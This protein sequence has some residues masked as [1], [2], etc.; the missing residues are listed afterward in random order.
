VAYI[1]FF[2]VFE[3]LYNMVGYFLEEEGRKGA[4]NADDGDG[5]SWE[6]SMILQYSL[7]VT[8]ANM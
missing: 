3:L 2:L 7:I 5:G 1:Y 4:G 6:E 8:R